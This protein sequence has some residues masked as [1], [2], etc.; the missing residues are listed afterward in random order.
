MDKVVWPCLDTNVTR[1]LM[2]LFIHS[3]L[4]SVGYTNKG[5][6]RAWGHLAVHTLVDRDPRVVFRAAN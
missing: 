3:F 4:E 6:V 1:R 5:E 2:T